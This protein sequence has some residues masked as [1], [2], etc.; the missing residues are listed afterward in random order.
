ADFPDRAI[1]HEIDRGEPD[2]RDPVCEGGENRAHDD[3]AHADFAVENA[4][5]VEVLGSAYAAL[6]EPAVRPVGF[7]CVAVK[8]AT[9]TR[10]GNGVSRL[11]GR[12]ERVAGPA[13][14]ADRVDFPGPRHIGSPWK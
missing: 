1:N 3:E 5:P 12:S 6:L 4:L 11:G 7:R 14:R 8:I 10:A 2:E 13:V 9:A